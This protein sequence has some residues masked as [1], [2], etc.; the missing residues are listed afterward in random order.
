MLLFSIS[1]PSMAQPTVSFTFDD[2]STADRPG[3]AFETWNQLILDH[4]ETA[5]LTAAFFVTGQNK[6]SKKGQYL[7][8]SWADAGHL[9]GNHTF[10]H[11]NYSK[12]EN[13]PALFK[14]EL[15]KTDNIIAAYSTYTKRFRFPYLKEGNSPEK[16]AA[17]RQILDAQGYKNGYVTIDAS[18]WYIDSRLVTRLKADPNAD[19]EA[20]KQYYIAHLYER[21]QF[22][23]ELSYKINK[24]H[25][26]HTLLL[27]HNLASALFLD[28][29]IAH[30]KAK[31]WTIVSAKEAF[32]DP[33]YALRPSYAGESL[34]YALARDAKTFDHLLRIPPE[35]S[36]FE[37]EKM[38]ALGL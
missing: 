7:L 11:P 27:H 21:A 30:F 18:D 35:D 31:G 12:E 9:I 22:Y 8:K 25:V 23:E 26:K 20:F 1:I 14:E 32:Q 34:I 37:K 38:D 2:G 10:T 24:R 3:Y 5:N 13:G 28:D 4:L 29:L 15:I 16:V 17:Y 36:Q 19:I 6:T 33:I